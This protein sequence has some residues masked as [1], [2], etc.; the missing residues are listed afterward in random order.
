MEDEV[1]DLKRI[2]R[3]LLQLPSMQQQLE[4]LHK[5]IGTATKYAVILEAETKSKE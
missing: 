5:G 3:E 4:S 2:I 1:K